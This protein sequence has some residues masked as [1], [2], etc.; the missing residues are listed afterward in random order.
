MSIPNT[1]VGLMEIRFRPVSMWLPL[2]CVQFGEIY[3]YLTT[4]VV[5]LFTCV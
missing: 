3:Q 4:L 5:K 1:N 2:K